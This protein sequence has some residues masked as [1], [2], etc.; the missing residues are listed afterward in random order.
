VSQLLLEAELPFHMSSRLCFTGPDILK[1]W[2]T[3]SWCLTSLGRLRCLAAVEAGCE[4]V[5]GKERNGSDDVKQ[6]ETRHACGCQARGTEVRHP[7]PLGRRIPPRA[8]HRRATLQGLALIVLPHHAQQTSTSSLYS[9]SPLHTTPTPSPPP[10]SPP[11]HGRAQ[12]PL[13]LPE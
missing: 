13:L 6:A 11:N 8:I 9:A 4:G 12:L 3:M 5:C 10:S 2:L 1:Q 7:G